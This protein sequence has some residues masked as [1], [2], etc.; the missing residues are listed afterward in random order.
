M[1]LG[2]VLMIVHS[3]CPADPRVRR[4]AE[5]LADRGWGVDVLC[6]R[7]EGEAWR[8]EVGGVNYLRFPLRRRRGGALRYA[9]EYLALLVL[10]TLAIIGLHGAR[11][12]RAVQA[13]NMPDFLVFCGLVPWLTGVPL[14]VDLHDPV[15]ELY[16]SKFGLPRQAPLIRMLTGIEGAAIHFAESVLVA[17]GAFRDRL[18]ARGRPAGKIHVLLNS[19]DPKLFRPRERERRSDV[20]RV[21]FHGT[22]TRRSGVDQLVRAA[23]K[24][25]ANGTPLELVI[26]GDGDFLPELRELAAEGDRPEWVDVRGPVPLERVPE[27]V[28]SAD[29]GVVP[30]RGGEFHEL[31]LPT[32]LFEYLSMERPVVVSRSPAI[33]D[34]FSEDDLLF[35]E[36]DDEEDLAR[37]LGRAL[38]DS[39]HCEACVAGGG[40]VAHLHRWD[41]EKRIYLEVIDSLVVPDSG[42]TPASP[43]AR[44]STS[45]R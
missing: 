23:E 6:L 34:L 18:L 40:R 2:N 30:N 17:T 20:P 29:L 24:V 7:N 42:T 32:R 1:T 45:E 25:R 31:A 15:P 27:A 37:T 5:A 10:G 11:R 16:M 35:F 12:Y 28:A 21:L 43:P 41:K 4:E 44:S 39:A 26:L 14:V 13:H 3:Y 36:P 33:S 19:P 22:V 9:F 38:T 8:E